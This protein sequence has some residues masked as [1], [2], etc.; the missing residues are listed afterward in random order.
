VH[1]SVAFLVTGAVC[2]AMGILKAR[3]GLGR[4]G[5]TLV[6]LGTA[7]LLPTLITGFLAK[8]SITIPTGAENV[9][10]L[11]ERLGLVASAL[12]VGS[13]F[14]KAWGGGRLAAGQRLPYAVLLLV[15]VLVVVAV[16]ATGGHMVYRLSVG[17]D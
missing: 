3:D 9:V 4:F 1:F 16:A 15:G 5:G 11:H 7:S 14:V 12:F 6:L 13:Q 2:E 17:I 10:A 8:N